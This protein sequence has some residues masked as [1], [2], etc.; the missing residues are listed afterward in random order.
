M[1]PRRT[2]KMLEEGGRRVWCV[3]DYA[4]SPVAG[5]THAAKMMEACPRGWHPWGAKIRKSGK[6]R[7]ASVEVVFRE[8]AAKT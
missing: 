7:R 2:Q 4:E 5:C 6:G 3:R 1:S 8:N